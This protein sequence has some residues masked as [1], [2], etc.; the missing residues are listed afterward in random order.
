M[1]A[2][3]EGGDVRWADGRREPL[4]AIILATGYRPDLRYL[5][6]TGALGDDGRPLHRGGVSTT[7]TGLGYVGLEYQR[8]V[9]SATVRGVGADAHRVVARLLGQ[10]AGARFPTPAG[11]RARGPAA[12]VGQG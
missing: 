5:A 11:W 2:R 6:A 12:A 3:L 4:D 10:R 9:A 7:V 1:F 8:S